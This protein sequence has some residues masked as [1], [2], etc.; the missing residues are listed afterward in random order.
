MIIHFFFPFGKEQHVIDTG[1]GKK[2]EGERH[3]MC[4]SK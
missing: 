3:L 2:G 4:N 1:R